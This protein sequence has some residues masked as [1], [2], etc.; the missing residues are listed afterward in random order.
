MIIS[1]K[2]KDKIRSKNIVNLYDASIIID[3]LHNIRRSETGTSRL[4]YYFDACIGNFISKE[5]VLSF[6]DRIDENEFNI[7]K[8]ALKFIERQ[9]D[10][11]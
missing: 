9:V 10:M 4:S 7:S 11:I 2:L 3:R 1:K 8:K 5:N 6:I